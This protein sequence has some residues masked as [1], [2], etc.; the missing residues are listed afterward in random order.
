MPAS[1]PHDDREPAVTHEALFS[2]I[3]ALQM[4]HTNLSLI[5]LSGLDIHY[6]KVI[7]LKSIHDQSEVVLLYNS[8][9]IIVPII[10]YEQVMPWGFNLHAPTG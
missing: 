1:Y 3:I 2:H 5:G 7:C 6:I 10:L 8:S 9:L 4:S